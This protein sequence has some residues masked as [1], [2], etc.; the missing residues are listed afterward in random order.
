MKVTFQLLVAVA[1]L[2]VSGQFVSAQQTI[3]Y[4]G[5]PFPSQPFLAQR[6][7]RPANY[8]I[9]N[10]GTGDVEAYWINATG[11]EEYYQTI[12]AGRSLQQRTFVGHSWVLR[13]ADTGAVLSQETVRSALQSRVVAYS[14]RIAIPQPQPR[15]QPQPQPDRR[16]IPTPRPQPDVMPAPFN[17][18]ATVAATIDYI[19]QIR[20][21]PAAFRHLHA[22]LADRDVEAKPALIPNSSLQEAAQRKADFMAR[23][24]QF[25][26][27]MN[28]NGQSV[29]MNQW[30]REAGYELAAY[31]KNEQTTFECLFFEGGRNPNDVGV[32]AINAFLTEGKDG[33]H[34][35]GMLNRDMRVNNKDIGIG[36]ATAA[37]GKT[38]VSVVI[39]THDPRNP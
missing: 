38:Y 34:V 17:N 27:V 6:Q 11:R 8:E 12:P 26:H 28:I 32:R 16:P 13:R 29:G 33:G 3:R 19:N 30:M 25:G 7:P 14:T 15:P 1:L 5:Q 4:G 24:G 36:I 35:K 9:V 22:S 39:A 23:T 20:A 10:R 37:D 31:L 18:E 21:N 2:L